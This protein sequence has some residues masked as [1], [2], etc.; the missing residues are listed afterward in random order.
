MA[1]LE[2]QIAAALDVGS[3]WFNA[4][5]FQQCAEAY[6]DCAL[7]CLS[8]RELPADCAMVLEQAIRRAGMTFR[9]TGNSEQSAWQLRSALDFTLSAL[10]TSGCQGRNSYPSYG[11]MPPMFMAANT[12]S[13]SSYGWGAAPMSFSQKPSRYTQQMEARRY[14]LQRNIQQTSSSGWG[15]PA[16]GAAVGA[17]GGL[18]AG[19]LLTEAAMC[20]YYGYGGMS[21]FTPALVGGALGA[22]A[23]SM[24]RPGSMTSGAITGGLGGA[25]GGMMLAGADSPTE[26]LTMG[27]GMIG[28]ASL[29]GAYGGVGGAA[30]GGVLGGTAGDFVV[31]S[32]PADC[33]TM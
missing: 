4:G 10:A 8:S 19:S 18:A 9:E 2:Q 12:V 17:L 15:G 3:R 27:A 7:R 6:H 20:P 5:Q 11:A 25:A 21:D 29:G 32:G 22:T 26:A 31:N 23:G 30:L 13:P 28:G 14:D 33:L 16:T 1:S 24:A